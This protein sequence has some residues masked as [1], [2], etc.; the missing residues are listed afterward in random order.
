MLGRWNV[1]GRNIG[2]TLR[3][4]PVD[5]YAVPDG[6]LDIPLERLNVVDSR[7]SLEAIAEHIADYVPT[8]PL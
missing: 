5:N 8:G 1:I 7:F 3:N 4:G 6:L 2:E